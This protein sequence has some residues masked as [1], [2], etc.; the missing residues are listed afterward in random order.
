MPRQWLP[1]AGYASSSLIP[2]D[3]ETLSNHF[4]LELHSKI[5]TPPECLRIP[6]TPHVQ[7]SV[8]GP[9]LLSSVVARRASEKALAGC[10]S[11]SCLACRIELVYM[12]VY[13][14]SVDGTNL[15]PGASIAVVLTSLSIR[16]RPFSH[17]HG[18][19][20]CIP[21]DTA[22]ILLGTMSQS[23]AVCKPRHRARDLCRKHCIQRCYFA[24]N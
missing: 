19:S 16:Q 14:A 8:V 18:K 20:R 17:G 23:A 12:R 10:L 3:C 5:L 2:P 15:M 22:I 11:L 6:L 1:R 13:V 21:G 4:E 9:S 24:D 7:L